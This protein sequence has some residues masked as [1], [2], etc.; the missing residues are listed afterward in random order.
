MLGFSTVANA[1][2]SRDITATFEVLYAPWDTYTAEDIFHENLTSSFKPLNPP[3]SISRFGKEA[4]LRTSLPAQQPGHSVTILELP[5]QIFN[6]IDVWFRYSDGEVKHYYAGDQYPYVSRA[7]KH[8]SAAFPIPIDVNGPIEILIRARNETTHP[9][10]FA[11]WVWPED[12]WQEYLMLKRA[13]YGAFI[14]AVLVLCLYNLFLG[15]TLRDSS[16]LFYV[17]YVLC[18]TFSVILLSGLAEEYLWPEGKPAPFVLA[19]TGLGT[20]LAVGFVNQFLKIRPWRP[21][22]Y[23]ISTLISALALICGVILVFSHSLPVVPAQYSASFVHFLLLISAMYFIGTSLVSYFSGVTQARFLALSMFALLSCMAAYF[24]YTYG[25]LAYNTVIG[26]SLEIGT[27][28]EGIL[29]SLALADRIT[30]LTRDKQAAEQTAFEAQKSF[31]KQ[32]IIAREKERQNISEVLHDS[33]GHAVLVLKNSLQSR[34][35]SLEKQYSITPQQNH[36][37]LG[38][39]IGQCGEI[40]SDVRRLSHDLHPHILQR[41]GLATAIEATFERALEPVQ[42]KWDLD[43]DS[44]PDELEPELEI[45]AYRVIQEGLNNILKHASA[46]AVECSIRASQESIQ[47]RLF[48]NG[49][50]FNVATAGTKTLGLQESTARIQILG[51]RFHVESVFGRG[52]TIQF[53]VPLASSGA[54]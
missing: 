45:T 50:G 30:I 18:L 17:G 35:G 39:E 21:R 28:A 20:F 31:S 54:Q 9:M 37:I 42:I 15:F 12:S 26:H 36:E 3:A 34:A 51:G 33:I 29:L 5:G 43:I 27:L 19:A 41:L 13:W 22:L 38:D 49:V 11:A 23:W 32:L 25:L 47:C 7:I 48:D 2:P 24:S 6:Y 16:Y 14:G 53:E 10:N 46:T 4:W 1:L 8:A 44:L 52:T 40:M